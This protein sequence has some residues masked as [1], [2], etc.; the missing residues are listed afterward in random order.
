MLGVTPPMAQAPVAGQATSPFDFQS[1]VAQIASLPQ[2]QQP[3]QQLEALRKQEEPLATRYGQMAAQP[4]QTRYQPQYEPITGLK[5][6][7]RDV[8]RGILQG[9]SLTGPGQRVQQAIYGP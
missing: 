7:L 4:P 1:M 3:M 2:F 9:L 6:G 5:S 8:G